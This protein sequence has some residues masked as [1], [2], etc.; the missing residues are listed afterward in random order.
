MLGCVGSLFLCLFSPCLVVLV[1][2]S[3]V[4]GVLVVACMWVDLGRVFH[5]VLSCFLGCILEILLVALRDFYLGVL[6]ITHP[7]IGE[8]WPSGGGP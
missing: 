7:W 4:V 2:A 8:K 6:G 3:C 5:F 1:F